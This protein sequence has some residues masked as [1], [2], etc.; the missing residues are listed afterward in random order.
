MFRLAHLS[1]PH[2]GPLPDP[3]L[4]ELA[5]KR[6]LGYVNWRRNRAAAHTGAH[7]RG[8]IGDLQT[9]GFDHLAITGDLVNLALDSEIEAA[10]RWLRT[11]GD[12][13]AISVVPGNHDAYIRGALDKA[14]EAWAAH[15]TG[16]GAFKPAFPFV[17]RRGSVAIIGTSSALA[18]G[19]FMATGR[20][21]QHDASALRDVLTAARH[22]GLF[23]VVLIHHPPLRDITG[24]YA[25]LVGAALFRRVV[26][27]AGA[28][29]VLHGHTHRD[30][31]N[32]IDGPDG[33]VPV[34]GVPSASS[35]PG[36]HKP[37]GRYNLFEIS[38][39]PGSWSCTMRERGWTANG[40]I[41][42]IGGIRH[43][44]GESVPA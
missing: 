44:A 35:G 1:D 9:I 42:P 16:D 36:R 37:A 40:V 28:E 30:S 27:E 5:S 20:F 12:P 31:L 2:L 33:P 43:L 23:R 29:L 6:V 38:G 17:R 4:V 26:A 8:L 22:S 39:E 14:I 15:M 24:W 3:K 10:A 7:L 18:T 34:C 25:R 19:P 13:Q 21:T 41:E 11:I 32:W